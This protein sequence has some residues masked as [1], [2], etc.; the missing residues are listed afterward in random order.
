MTLSNLRK[1]LEEN[2]QGHLLKFWE[3]LSDDEKI[4]FEKELNHVD[5][6]Y[7]NHIYQR[8]MQQ[9]RQDQEKKDELMEPLPGDVFARLSETAEDKQMCWCKE[10]LKQ[11]SQGK[12]AVLLLAGGQGTRLGV[13]YP[14]GMYDVGL[15]SHKT[16]YQLQAERILKLQDVAAESHGNHGVITWYVYTMPPYWGN[17]VKH[18]MLFFVM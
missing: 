11:I 3:K 2:G 15:P 13:S 5:F 17:K 18:Y 14:K 6:G 4:K 10:G 16:L 1:K 8:A 7:V 12:V 9:L